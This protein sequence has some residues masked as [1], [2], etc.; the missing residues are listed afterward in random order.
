MMLLPSVPVH[1]HTEGFCH[2][3]VLTL[4]F[5]NIYLLLVDCSSVLVRK[6]WLLTG[7]MLVLEIHYVDVSINI[8]PQLLCVSKTMLCISG[9]T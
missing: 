9:K 1:Q 4:G 3:E 2:S 6:I 7:R 8:Q 5:R